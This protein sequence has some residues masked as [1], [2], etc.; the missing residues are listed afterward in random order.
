MEAICDTLMQEIHPYFQPQG[1]LVW[2]SH[3]VMFEES[4]SSRC[5]Q[6]QRNTN[7]Q[8]TQFTH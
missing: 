7:A 6:A 4:E 5:R 3:M 2:H 8:Y 1:L